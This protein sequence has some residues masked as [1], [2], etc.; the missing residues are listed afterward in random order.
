MPIVISRSGTVL[1]APE[2]SQ[3]QS[4]KMWETLV[5]NWAKKHPEA[6]KQAQP[7]AAPTLPAPA[8]AADCAG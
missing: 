8:A 1:S 7:D 5:R 6:L 2:I 4:N 3:E